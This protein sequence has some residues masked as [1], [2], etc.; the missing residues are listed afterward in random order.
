MTKD[1]PIAIALIDKFFVPVINAESEE[2][3]RGWLRQQSTEDI[4]R[5]LALFADWA[6]FPDRRTILD[7]ELARRRQRAVAEEG[8]EKRPPEG[9][10]SKESPPQEV[11]KITRQGV[12]AIGRFPILVVAGLFL[13]V[14]IVLLAVPDFRTTL[15]TWITGE[16]V[17][18]TNGPEGHWRDKPVSK[19]LKKQGE[20]R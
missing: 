14:L 5:F 17:V 9:R 3:L 10:P 16:S 19:W 12:E 11:L 15:T 18:V 2:D 1:D 4:E 20:D 6:S 13:F 8:A 7:Q